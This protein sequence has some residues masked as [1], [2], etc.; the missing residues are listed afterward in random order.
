MKKVRIIVEGVTLVGALEDTETAR[1]VWD[2]LPF[3]SRVNT[4][5]DE[6]YFDIPAEI[7]LESDAG[8]D[9]EVGELGYWPPGKAFCVFFGP[10]PASTGDRPRAASP[11]N[12]FGRIE[13]DP[14]V[15]RTVSD[16]SFVRVEQLEDI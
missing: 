14:A 6:I 11:V 4:W 1:K 13:G 10:T 7:D 3:E 9:V 8:A 2:T 5:G 16:G 12:V 15:L